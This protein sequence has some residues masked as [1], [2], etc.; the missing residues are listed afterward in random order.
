[1]NRFILKSPSPIQMELGL[2]ITLKDAYTQI[3]NL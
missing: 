1:M 2:E 3:T